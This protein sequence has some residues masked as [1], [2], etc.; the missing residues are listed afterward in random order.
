MC[1]A[2]KDKIVVRRIVN[3]NFARYEQEFNHA[4]TNSLLTEEVSE[5]L[6]AKEEVDILDAL[7]DIAYVAIGA[8]WKM[9][10]SPGGIHDA[11]LAVCDSNDSKTTVKT[12]SYIKANIDKGKD[13]VPP[14]VRL[15]EILDDRL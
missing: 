10:L 1:E 3:W 11:L 6:Q 7:V 2:I 4:L 12:A 13:F 9:G 14:E 8:M 5:L 15:Q